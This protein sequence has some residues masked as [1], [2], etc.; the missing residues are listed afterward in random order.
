MGP[1]GGG[2]A[3]PRGQWA[4]AVEA[5]IRRLRTGGPGRPEEAVEDARRLLFDYLPPGYAQETLP[6]DAA[7]DC[8]S[9]LDLMGA[10]SG[11][12]G[13]DT[14]GSGGGVGG[15][16]LMAL[17]APRPGASG[18]FR[19]RRAG[20]RRVELS[21]FLRVLESFGL[22][23]VEAVPWHFALADGR[24]SYV[25]DIG[26]RATAPS[27]RSPPD[28]VG[29]AHERTGR[30]QRLIDAISAVAAGHCELTSLDGLVLGAGLSWQEVNLLGSYCHYRRQC[31]GGRAVDLAEALAE[32]LVAYPEAAAA[33][34]RL[35]RALLAPVEPQDGGERA[36]AQ[37]RSDVARLLAGVPDRRHDAALAE[38]VAMVEATVRTSWS[39]DAAGGPVALKL[40]SQ[41]VPFLPNP[42][43]F[44]E[45][46]VWS[47]WF[48]GLHLRFGPVARGGVRWSDRV[49]DLRG[50]V[51]ELA[52]A[53][54]KKNSL[55]VPTGAKGAFVLRRTAPSTLAR[56]APTS[57]PRPRWPAGLRRLYWCPARPDRQCG[58]RE[59]RAPTHH[60]PGRGRPL[61]GGGGGQG[62][63]SLL[64]SGQRAQCGPG[65]LAGRRLC[66]G[67]SQGYDHKALGITAKGAWLAVRRHF[68]ALAM[69]ATTAPLRVAGVGDMSGDVFGNG[70]LQSRHLRLVAAFDH[71]HIFVDPSPDPEASYEERAR[72]SRLPGSS[73]ADYDLA[74]ASPGAA[75][76]PRGAKQVELSPQARDALGAPERLVAPPDLVRAVLRAPVDLLFFGGVGTFV[77]GPGQSD[78]EVEDGANDEVRLDA[79]QLRARVV[80]E[81]ANL[82]LTQPARAAYSRRGG[83]VNADF[84]DNAAG[85]ALSDREVNMKVLLQLAISKGAL[86]AERRAALLVEAEGEAATKVLQQVDDGI[87][88]VDRA[89]ASSPG[90]LPAY[91]A[92]LAD[93]E[94]EGLLDRQVEALPSEEELARRAQAGAGFS[95]PEL[96]VLV[97][98]ARSELARSIDGSPLATAA[99]LQELVLSYFPGP[100]R[101]VLADLVPQHP[102]ARSLAA[103][104][105]ANEVL[106]TMGPVWA[107]ESA[108]E[109]GRP[110]YEAAAAYWGARQ[111]LGLGPLAAQLTAQADSWPVEA[112]ERARQ[113]LADGV[114]QLAR[115][116]LLHPGPVR[117]VEL[118]AAD[119]HLAAAAE[120]VLGPDRAPGGRPG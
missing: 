118:V 74:Q 21:S 108:R 83:R 30:G 35:F 45:V 119:G 62:H 89:A 58:G 94:A 41:S 66:L 97:A 40:A 81:G 96:A 27:D 110:S 8:L 109:T 42:R 92:L 22:V 47:P 20:R 23:A 111:V 31:G 112:E 29:V 44:A 114:G 99:E 60:V 24:D 5:E 77:R 6:A 14:A 43:P 102:L 72:L 68:R 76:Y 80:A 57:R 85:V 115:W 86:S 11:D 50:E 70:M 88:A 26:L 52:R 2:T 1:T 103:S 10:P 107:H 69:D 55:I 38:L 28:V 25:D 95:R 39:P 87:V 13:A 78:A 105:L 19:L 48:E 75:V 12:D 7:W 61:P 71:R 117:P 34:V 37:A 100:F 51:L 36:A 17:A 63:R 3:G 9:L 67:G 4:E 82:A 79:G 18:D 116:Y 91:G 53:Q 90:D 54:V 33:A 56:P 113:A 73:W 84:V 32:A 16:G 49:V 15:M 101:R 120:A 46:Y 65:L 106:T 93:L 59:G 104:Q 64:G 98:Y